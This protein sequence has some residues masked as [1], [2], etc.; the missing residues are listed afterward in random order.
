MSNTGLGDRLGKFKS[1][2]VVAQILLINGVFFLLCNIIANLVNPTLI[3]YFTMPSNLTEL[4]VRFYTP[5]T[6]MFTHLN[7]SHVFFNMI[8][9]YFMGEIFHP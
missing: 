5:F 4:V 3:N 7:F 9:F 2:S 8:T 6:Y 1:F